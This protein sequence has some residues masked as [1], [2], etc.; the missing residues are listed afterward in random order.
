MFEA[1]I[2]TA[3]FHCSGKGL[4]RRCP[5]R[6]GD[7]VVVQWRLAVQWV[8]FEFPH[9]AIRPLGAAGFVYAR[10][11]GGHAS[12][13]MSVGMLECSLVVLIL[14]LPVPSLLFA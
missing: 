12:R 7:A 9:G 10:I 6:N 8:G 4:L 11:A 2:P 14:F 5:C 13:N 1:F 3:V